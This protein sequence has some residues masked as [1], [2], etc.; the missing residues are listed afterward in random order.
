MAKP[1]LAS[2]RIS[3]PVS[4]SEPPR[5]PNIL[6][7]DDEREM[8]ELV[9]ADL[10]RRGYDVSWRTSAKETLAAFDSSSFTV[11]LV[12]INMEELGG[13]EL[14]RAALVKQP[15]L[16]VVVMTGFGS[17]EHAIGAIRAGAFDFVTKP[18]SMNMLALRLERAL[19]QRN[20]QDEL[21]R[22]RQRV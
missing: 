18:I 1:V 16:L 9:K 19:R 6:V 17:M 3:A 13:L 22:L 14:C 20:L 7:V 5:T 2:A 11:L 15:D 8:C 21:E 4:V 10:T 12:D